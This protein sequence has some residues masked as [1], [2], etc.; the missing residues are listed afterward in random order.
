MASDAEL[1]RRSMGDPEAFGELYDRHVRAI[2]AWLG[3]AVGD[4]G[5]AGEL[6]AEVFAQALQSRGRFRELG[7]GSALP[8]LYG[9]AHNVLRRFR[10]THRVETAARERLGMPLD[11]VVDG[12]AEMEDRL[13]LEQAAAELEQAL[14]HLPEGQRHAV[15]LR[16]GD[17]LPFPA[18][19]DRLG[20]TPVTARVRVHRALASL[21]LM[22]EEKTT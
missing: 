18:I 17:E 7:D 15:I 8:W 10:R 20:C 3:R 19:A 5:V 14:L 12:F 2:R 13:V 1:I 9:I 21:R 11:I 4:A 16:F 6:T 22:L